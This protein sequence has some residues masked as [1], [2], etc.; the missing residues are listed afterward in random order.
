M[1]EYSYFIR[2]DVA[3]SG[4]IYECAEKLTDRMICEESADV[5][6]TRLV[7]FTDATDNETFREIARLITRLLADRFPE[8]HP[9][10]SLVAQRPLEADLA[11]GHLAVEAHYYVLSPRQTIRY[12]SFGE[13]HY[14][15]VEGESSRE[16]FLS[17]GPHN[18][19]LPE[20]VPAQAE[21]I[22]GRVAEILRRESFPVNSIQRQWN[23]VE[24]ITRTTHGCQHYQTLND[25]RSEFYALEPWPDG[26]PAATGIGVAAG[27]ITVDLNAAVGAVSHAIDNPLQCAA[28]VYSERVLRPGDRAVPSTPKFERARVVEYDGC[29]LCHVSGTAAIRR[30]ESLAHADAALQTK[31]TIENIAQLTVQVSESC[32]VRS[33]RVYVKRVEDMGAVEQ[34]V[35]AFYPEADLL[36]VQADV[37]RPELLVEI[38]ALAVAQ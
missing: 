5:V 30:E 12:E 8:R 25:A 34:V 14:V 28:H 1:W 22:F 37:C 24:G 27:G 20:C 23:Y 21:I 10:W 13:V 31:V 33:A 29:Y 16:L 9:V 35:T 19:W 26:Y 2:T 36:F 38:E 7:Y 6:L 15:V 11:A 32:C 4:D 18:S 17:V 3:R